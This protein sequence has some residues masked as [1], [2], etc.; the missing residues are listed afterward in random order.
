VLAELLN[1]PEIDPDQWQ[2][3]VSRLAAFVRSK[4]PQTTLVIGPTFWQRPDALPAL[5]PLDDLN[6]VYA[7][8]FYDPMVFTHQ[9]HWD[10]DNPLSRIRG[11]PFPFSKSDAAVR[12]L[13]DTL[14]QNGDAAAL[15][16]LDKALVGGGSASQIASGFTPAVRWQ[17][18]YHRP[19]MVNEFG[20]LK[21]GAPVQSRL[22]WL[23]DVVDEAE[24]HCWGWTHWEYAAGF[25]FINADGRPDPQTLHV[26]LDH[27]SR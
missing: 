17:E 11:L 13:R 3:V 14:S 18:K 6:I 16:E 8:H 25:G 26:L 23:G 15:G 27:Q 5:H 4:L 1:E 21:G 20:V 10:R 2:G 19:L 9:G 7:L 24:R 22:R 12:G